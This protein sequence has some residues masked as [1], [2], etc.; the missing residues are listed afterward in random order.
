MDFNTIQQSLIEALGWTLLHSLWQGLII[1]ALLA[2]TIR[3]TKNKSPK[4]SYQI[5]CLSLLSLV[6]WMT[7]TF[8]NHFHW[9]ADYNTVLVTPNPTATGDDFSFFVSSLSWQQNID[10]FFQSFIQSYADELVMLW[11][12]GVSV[13]GLRWM[14]AIYFTYTL[15]RKNISFAPAAWQQ[16]VQQY[17]RKLGIKKAVSIVKSTKVDVPMVIGHL[18]PVILMPASIATGFTNAQ[19]ESII[20]HELAHIKN[21]DF[22]IGLILSA[23]EVVLFYHPLYWWVSGIIS[24]EREK[25][26][27]DIAVAQCGNP[28][29]YARTLF[30]IAE[31]KQQ[32]SLAL[33]LQG[34]KNQLFDRIKRICISPQGNTHNNHNKAGMALG[35]LFVVAI[36]ALAQV[37]TQ[38]KDAILEPV[39]DAFI[40]Q[41]QPPLDIE[42]ESIPEEVIVE[43]T[44][45]EEIV[46]STGFNDNKTN[47]FES[48][49]DGV[50]L[51]DTIIPNNGNKV[52]L[53][54]KLDQDGNIYI[55]KKDTDGQAYAYIIKNNQGKIYIDQT[56]LKPGNHK[57]SLSPETEILF[58]GYTLI[59]DR[60]DIDLDNLDKVFDDNPKAA[61]QYYAE[62][63]KQLDADFTGRVRISNGTEN[64]E[65]M[66]EE[67]AEAEEAMERHE[68]A[69][70]QQREN[71]ERQ[72][73]AMEQQREEMER[74]GEE[75]REKMER[76]RE[77]MEQQH[78]ELQERAERQRE[79]MERQRE[80]IERQREEIH[81]QMEH[82]R[83]ELQR[84]LEEDNKLR[85][86]EH[87][88]TQEQ[89]D[90][91]H[92]MLAVE[93]Q[94]DGLTKK[95]YKYKFELSFYELKVNKEVLSPELHKKY[96]ELYEKHYDIKLKE[97]SKVKIQRT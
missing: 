74:Q 17:S 52:I 55:T 43:E 84:K 79:E 6:V 26:C 72:Q 24:E 37:P 65:G 85:E 89:N 7:S 78:E 60:D 83:E 9:P 22:I 92:E 70:E 90:Q 71:M 97:N 75:I 40:E 16:M 86:E 23:M 61:N 42:E 44:K 68:E 67:F 1:A 59:L 13:F 21:N 34:K 20:V 39:R 91:F 80:E 18:K 82:Q 25:H 35:L 57:L 88:R 4:L 87:N 46:T 11:L 27:D 41:F 29:L 53:L 12:L 94:K 3:I 64:F 56:E 32:K 63:K 10:I 45:V 31:Q 73:E 38:A 81:E 54:T 50:L 58:I 62:A 33:S 95:K 48:D 2:I 19:I 66:E 51:T 28:L 36:M 14:G 15:K 5:C 69:M 93:F 30:N 47:E 8:I 76:Q 77:E 49:T 96:L